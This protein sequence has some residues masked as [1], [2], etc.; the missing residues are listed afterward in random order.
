MAIDRRRFFKGGGLALIAAGGGAGLAPRRVF[1]ERAAIPT[2]RQAGLHP[3]DRHFDGAVGTRS[4][5]VDLD[6][7]RPIPRSASQPPQ[8]PVTLLTGPN[9]LD[10]SCGPNC[11]WSL[12]YDET[13]TRT[14]G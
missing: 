4:H 9:H 3:A 5:R 8:D 10:E 13:L 6:L 1:A 2:Q 11:Q 14:G 12:D 7:Q